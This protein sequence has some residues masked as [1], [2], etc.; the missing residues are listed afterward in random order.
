ME[1]IAR[2]EGEGRG[3]FTGS[4]GFLGLD[5]RAAFNILIRT[6]VWR[7]AAALGEVSFH[8]GGGITWSSDARA[9][10]DETLSEG[11]GSRGGP[12]GA[13]GR[14]SGE[15][16]RA[17]HPR[18]PSASAGLVTRRGRSDKVATEVRTLAKVVDM[19]QAALLLLP[20]LSFQP[21]AF[22]DPPP[23]PADKRP[24]VA[25]M[26]AK[27]KA[28]AGKDG[29]EDKDAI[30]VIDQRSRSSRTAGRRTRRRSSRR[31]RDASRSA[32]WRRK[33]RRRRTS[34]TS[35]PRRRWGRWGPR[36]RTP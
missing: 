7:P 16:G 31:S 12:R 2:L 13:V 20:L 10:D 5:G 8:V 11:R 33:A 19:I 6:L 14:I 23:E 35:L 25:E 30:A 34:S 18:G 26:L 15:E 22:Q 4:L 17:R 3:F 32:G 36:A 28:H 1:A 29:K 9:E 27:L 21:F 24:E